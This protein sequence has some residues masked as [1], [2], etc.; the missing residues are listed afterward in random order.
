MKMIFDLS[1]KIVKKVQ[2]AYSCKTKKQAIAV[3]LEE[4]LKK[5]K[6]EEFA[7]KIGFLRF[8]LSLKELKKLREA[9]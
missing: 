8:G 2:K 1:E 5:K 9:E 3:A 7:K 4:A 6:R